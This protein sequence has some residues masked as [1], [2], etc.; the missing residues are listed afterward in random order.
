MIMVAAAEVD[1]PG[2]SNSSVSVVLA[3]PDDAC[4]HV[5][6]YPAYVSPTSS[7][8]KREYNLGE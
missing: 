2:Y 6:L 1:S 5:P 3:V 8:R 4:V 7:F